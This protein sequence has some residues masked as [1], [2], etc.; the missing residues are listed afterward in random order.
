MFHED[1]VLLHGIN[2]ALLCCNPSVSLLARSFSYPLPL[3]FF[4]IPPL[5]PPICNSVA[6]AFPGR[7]STF[8][9]EFRRT[10][11]CEAARVTDER[12]ER[13]LLVLCE[14]FDRAING[15]RH[16]SAICSSAPRS[17]GKS[18]SRGIVPG[19]AEHSSIVSVI[20]SVR[21]ERTFRDDMTFLIAI[22]VA[23][24][25]QLRGR[26]SASVVSL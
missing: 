6:A 17:L 1:L 13:G 22:N 19:R 3:V 24:G 2:S 12:V 9:S 26:N 18:F 14:I 23:A 7:S 10:S 15:T 5:F 21:I 4:F 16:A 11:C 20:I 25:V 8:S